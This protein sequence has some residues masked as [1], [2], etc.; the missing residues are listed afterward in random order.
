MFAEAEKLG[1]IR[2]AQNPPWVLTDEYDSFN[3]TLSPSILRNTDESADTAYAVI[4]WQ[5]DVILDFLK[6]KN[7]RISDQKLHDLS[8]VVFVVMTAM[9]K[10]AG[11]PYD[12]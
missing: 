9:L 11:V 4:D 6:Q 1:I 2:T 7:I 3:R 8:M 12:R 5:K 10:A